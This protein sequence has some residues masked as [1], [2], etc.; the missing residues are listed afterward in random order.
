MAKDLI[1]DWVALIRRQN[2][3]QSKHGRLQM[4]NGR[5]LSAQ[6]A[7]VMFSLCDKFGLSFVAKHRALDCFERVLLKM[8][9][10]L[11]SSS[12]KSWR[13]SRRGSSDQH[14]KKR[15]PVERQI[16]CKA[17]DVSNRLF[18]FALACVQLASKM[19]NSKSTVDPGV[20]NEMFP[21]VT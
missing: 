13:G 7:E 19:E 4:L 21:S 10:R 15:S 14:S 12:A 3:K 2:L 20:V 9:F 17:I 16:T 11:S 8:L 6:A 18:H 5:D 1:T